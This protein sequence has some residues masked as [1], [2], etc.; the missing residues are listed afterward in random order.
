MPGT[1]SVQTS[2][3]D[4]RI[5]PELDVE[6]DESAGDDEVS[7]RFAEIGLTPRTGWYASIA[8]YLV[9]SL[10]AIA[11]PLIAPD[12]FPRS[13]IWLGLAAFAMVPISIVGLKRFPNSVRATH[14][15]LGVGLA[16]Q[17]LGAVILGD[18][19][20]AFVMLPLTTVLPPA[21]YFGVREGTI[22]TMFAA[23][24]VAVF[25]TMI[26]EPWAWAMAV[27]STTAIV[28]LSISMMIAQARTRRIAREHRTL[29]YTDPLTGVANTRAL[30]Q[31]LA[32]E[33]RTAVAGG[34]AAALFAIDLDN[35]KSV[36]DELGYEA[37]DRLLVATAE[38][39]E[40]ESSD[41]DLVARRG[42]DE[43]SVVVG[44]AGARDL[45]GLKKAF[46]TAIIEARRWVCPGVTPTASVDHV[47]LAADDTIGSVL[48][49]A[50]DALHE[51]KTEVHAHDAIG[52]P[53]ITLLDQRSESERARVEQAAEAELQAGDDGF[54]GEAIGEWLRGTPSVDRP[55]WLVTA[56]MQAVI[57]VTLAVVATLALAP[58]FSMGE[59]LVVGGMLLALATASAV[60]G[61]VLLTRR[62]VHATFVA[63]IAILVPAVTLAGESQAALIDLFAIVG[64]FAFHTFRSRTAAVYLVAMI[65][66]YGYTAIAG[67]IPYAEARLTIFAIAML[68]SAALFGKVRT[69]TSRF[70]KQIWEFSQRD[71]L[72]GVANVRALRARLRDI[73][74]QARRRRARTAVIAIDLDEFKQ[75][76]DRFNHSIGDATLVAVAR[77]IED[78]VRADD[79]VARPGAAATSSS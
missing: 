60:A 69:V 47:L 64:L 12:S 43:F 44:D 48:E 76:N 53:R 77:A 33:T 40:R 30:H 55:I 8:L 34:P 31:R 36:N 71:A 56:S 54:G 65:A 19:V 70:L 18:A 79:L 11:L 66:A 57:G 13:L 17:V 24:M 5:E 52:R 50:D 6:H 38:A 45:D 23:V 67:G 16:I 75:V 72:T 14:F 2:E 46:A 22:Y 1:E 3:S 26:A 25:L 74:K 61:A 9:G 68:A 10:P 59:G 15:R 39:L 4:I 42:G 62:L 51:R 35:F 20:Q 27:C 63:S 32:I 41:G 73:T 29:A 28:T 21:I 78:N 7:Q 49:R 58:G 37:G